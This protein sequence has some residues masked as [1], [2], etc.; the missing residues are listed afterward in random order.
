MRF[1][2]L[3]ALEVFVGVLDHDDDRVHHRADGDGDA[4]QRH[5]V[6]AEALAE[7][8]QERRQHRD[9]QDQDGDQRAA[10]VHQEG[11]ADQRHHQAFLEELPF[12]RLDRAVNQR[13]A[14]VGDGVMDVGRQRLHRLVQAFLHVADHLARV[15][16]V[17]DHDDAPD[18]LAVAVEFGDAAPHLRS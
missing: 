2:A 3:V 4:A 18:G 16:A 11:E 13:A 10:Q 14:I 15:G 6:G 1:G 9:G 7:H 17:A 5:D 12:E 8:D